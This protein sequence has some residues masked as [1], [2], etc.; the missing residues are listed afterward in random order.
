MKKDEENKS[1]LNKPAE[2]SVSSID[3]SYDFDLWAATVKR[4]MLAALAK[5]K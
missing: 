3:N 2:T 5:A 4:Q 1:L